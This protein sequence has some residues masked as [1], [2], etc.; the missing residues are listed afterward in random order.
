ME[1]VTLK[2]TPLSAFA[3]LPKGDTLFGQILAYLNLNQ[4]DNKKILER[5]ETILKIITTFDCL[6]YDA[7]WICL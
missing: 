2:I 7:F 5:F 6:G 4:K 3:T 1:I